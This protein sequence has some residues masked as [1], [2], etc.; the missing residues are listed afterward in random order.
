MMTEHQQE[1]YEM[2]LTYPRTAAARKVQKRSPM[3]FVIQHGWWY[4]PGG[5]TKDIEQGTVQECHKNAQL[6]ANDWDSLT[7]CEGFALDKSGSL[8][9]VH[10]WVTDGTGRAIDS[11]WDRPALPTRASRSKRPSFG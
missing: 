4:E 5:A 1:L 2:L 11:T 7:Y 3:E 10:A 6:L 9:V 8:I